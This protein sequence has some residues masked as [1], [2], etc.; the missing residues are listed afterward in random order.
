MEPQPPPSVPQPLPPAP[1]SPPV[2]STTPAYRI[3]SVS[4]VVWATICGALIAGSVVLAIN[5]WRWGQKGSAVAAVAGG[6]IASAVVFWL[7]VV[8]PVGV[9][10][11]AFLVPQVVLGYLAARWLQGRRIDA[12]RAAGGDRVSPGIGALIGLGF[13]ALIIGAF[14]ALLLATHLIFGLNP[15]ALIDRVEYVDFGNGQLVYYYDGATRD[16]AQQ[17]GET[18][19]NAGYFDDTVPTEVSIAGPPGAHEISFVGADGA[20]D[21]PANVDYIGELT[22]YIA[23]DIGGTPITVLM[24]DLNLY[25]Q[26]RCTLIDTWQ[27][28][29]SR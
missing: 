10:A 6:F 14:A 8:V 11:V 19:T 29:P 7:A 18:L 17:L 21:D 4:G 20:W 15:G 5:Y 3:H 26:K 2:G 13:S 28:A 1:Q 9:P 22:E 16:D 12:H 25:E 24:L 27:C 23:P